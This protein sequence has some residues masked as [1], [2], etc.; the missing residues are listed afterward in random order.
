VSRVEDADAAYALLQ[1][2]LVAG[3]CRPAQVQL[4]TPVLRWLG[5]RLVGI[6][7]PG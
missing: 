3:D 5:D 4:A 6:E 7:V 1:T 2:E